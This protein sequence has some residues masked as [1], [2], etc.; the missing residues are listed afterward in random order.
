[1]KLG[2]VVPGGGLGKVPTLA[3]GLPSPA[4]CEI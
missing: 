3:G 2:W 4:R 1:M